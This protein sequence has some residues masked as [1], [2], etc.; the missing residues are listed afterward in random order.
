MKRNESVKKILLQMLARVAEEEMEVN[1]YE[2]PPVC[3]GLLH[4]PERPRL[5]ENRKRNNIYYEDK[6]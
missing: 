2:W 4:Q 5:D 6:R 1:I 3:V